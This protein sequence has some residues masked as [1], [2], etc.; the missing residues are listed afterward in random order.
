[1]MNDLL[2]KNLDIGIIGAGRVGG[3]LAYWLSRK[4]WRIKTVFSKTTQSAEKVANAI[5]TG[6]SDNLQNVFENCDVAFL[7]VNDSAIVPLLDRIQEFSKYKVKTL[8][9]CSG[10]LP[11]S[12]LGLAGLDFAKVSIHPHAPIPRLSTKR[13]PFADVLFGIE[14]DKFGE[15]FA[16]EIVSDLGGI[17]HHIDPAQKVLYHASGVFGSNFVY[18]IASV[19]QELLRESGISEELSKKT[20]QIMISRALQNFIDFGLPD[21][22]TGPVVRGDIDTVQA[23][24]SALKNT[25][26]LKFYIEGCRIAAKVAGKEKIFAELFDSI[27]NE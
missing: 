2:W 3:N 11:S 21:G 15:E 27:I 16:I 23:H 20:A 1:M 26:F 4:G 7:T 9:H 13:N 8:A 22:M 18:V 10:L 14:G 12:I 17:L 6:I 5:P 19:A 24:I 25:P